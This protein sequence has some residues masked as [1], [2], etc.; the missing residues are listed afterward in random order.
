MGRP[1]YRHRERSGNAA[2]AVRSDCAD[3][4][5]VHGAPAKTNP[6][7][8]PRA[9]C[10][11]RLKGGA[12]RS[13]NSRLRKRNLGQRGAT[14]PSACL[15]HASPKR[16]PGTPRRTPAQKLKLGKIPTPFHAW[17]PD[18]QPAFLPDNLLGPK[19]RSFQ[20]LED[21]IVTAL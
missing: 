4:P 21:E 13:R 14:R 2:R 7:L 15:P 18:H 6:A 8:S 16:S 20:G 3:R 12:T 5:A 17:P 19:L 11:A 1:G 9:A 10:K